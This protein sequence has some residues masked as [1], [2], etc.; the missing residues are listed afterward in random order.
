MLSAAGL[1]YSILAL[2]GFILFTIG[3][4]VRGMFANKLEQIM[5]RDGQD[6]EILLMFCKVGVVL[7]VVPVI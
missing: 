3:R 7:L 2:Y 4:F 6:Y 5:F 1:S